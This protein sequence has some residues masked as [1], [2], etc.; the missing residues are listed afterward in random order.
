MEQHAYTDKMKVFKNLEQG[1]QKYPIRPEII[2]VKKMVNSINFQN[3][4]QNSPNLISTQD[5]KEEL[6]NAVEDYIKDLNEEIQEETI[7]TNSPLARKDAD[8]ILLDFTNWLIDDN[9]EDNY[10]ISFKES[11]NHYTYD[12]KNNKWKLPK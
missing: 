3:G 4:L 8:H 2:E 11:P 12:L 10:S 9:D 6:L 1:L 5:T 7:R